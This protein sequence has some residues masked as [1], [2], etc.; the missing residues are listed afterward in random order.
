MIEV[1]SSWQMAV[2]VLATVIA[3][4]MLLVLIVRA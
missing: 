1:M 2:L 3:A 4:V